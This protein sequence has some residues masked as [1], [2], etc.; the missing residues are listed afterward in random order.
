MNEDISFGESSSGEHFETMSRLVRNAVPSFIWTLKRDD[1]GFRTLRKDQVV[2]HYTCAWAFT[3]KSGLCAHLRNLHHFDDLN[4]ESFFPRCYRLCCEYEREEFIDD[5]RITAAQALLKIVVS[6][7]E[8]WLVI[9][10]EINKVGE[11]NSVKENGEFYFQ[12]LLLYS[13]ILCYFSAID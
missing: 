7:S 11:E 2:N 3:T 5:F 12:M 13:A 1:I 9:K 10:K 6:E 4:A 8:K